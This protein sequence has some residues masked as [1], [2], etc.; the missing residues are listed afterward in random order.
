MVQG[1]VPDFKGHF[2]FP[3]FPMNGPT[4][5]TTLAWE[6]ISILTPARSVCVL[7]W[8]ESDPHA[9]MIPQQEATA[10]VETIISLKG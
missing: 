8:V 10:G 6:P 9:E 2:V 3:S 7:P 5:P 4:Y 1:A